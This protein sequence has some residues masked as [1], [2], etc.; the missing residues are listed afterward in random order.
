[1][2]A[3][4]WYQ[5]SL[6]FLK[7]TERGAD[8]L[9]SFTD[10]AYSGYG[11]FEILHRF[12]ERNQTP[13]IVNEAHYTPGIRKQVAELAKLIDDIILGNWQFA[14]R[15]EGASYIHNAFAI[16]P[17]KEFKLLKEGRQGIQPD[18]K[19]MI[20]YDQLLPFNNP[21]HNDEGCVPVEQL[22]LFYKK[23]GKN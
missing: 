4:S 23:K 9:K 13:Y 3:L 12:A 7:D 14:L 21:L 5:A 1:M 11:V 17:P 2:Q 20:I 16:F 19:S 22:P 10:T 18:T 8:C 6:Y 15:Y